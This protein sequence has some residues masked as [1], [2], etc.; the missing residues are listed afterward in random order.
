M[1]NESK[2]RFVNNYTDVYIEK[3]MSIIK[4]ESFGF[5]YSKCDIL[6]MP[7]LLHCADVMDI[8]DEEQKSVIINLLNQIK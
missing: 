5:I 8:F 4:N 7:V 3:Q 6:V 2:K 1:N